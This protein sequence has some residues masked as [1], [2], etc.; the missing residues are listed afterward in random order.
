MEKLK[1]TRFVGKTSL[2]EEVII[3]GGIIRLVR[4]IEFLDFRPIREIKV[5]LGDMIYDV[6]AIIERG[7]HPGMLVAS[8]LEDRGD[9]WLGKT[10][11]LLDP[12][13]ITLVDGSLDFGNTITSEL[14]FPAIGYRSEP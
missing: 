12:R 4:G 7:K 13:R 9:G 3:E 5:A 10:I 8:R 1:A 2:M 6:E 11:Y 14:L